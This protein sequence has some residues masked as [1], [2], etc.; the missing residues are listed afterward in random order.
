M[1]WYPLRSRGQGG[2]E[3]VCVSEV[4]ASIDTVDFFLLP[5]PSPVSRTQAHPSSWVGLVGMLAVV[6]EEALSTCTWSTQ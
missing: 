2:S 3:L 4:C 5:C 6:A 1:G